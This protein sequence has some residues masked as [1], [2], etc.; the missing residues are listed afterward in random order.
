MGGKK[1]SPRRQE[2]RKEYYKNRYE[3]NKIRK[4][5]K[6]EKRQEYFKQRNERFS[7][8][9]PKA[10]DS[11]LTTSIK[12]GYRGQLSKDTYTELIHSLG[13][14]ISEKYNLPKGRVKQHLRTTLPKP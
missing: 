2:R 3:E 13:I 11:Y 1:S 6:E 14:K 8:E 7:T 12:N 9:I 10:V 4:K 5:L